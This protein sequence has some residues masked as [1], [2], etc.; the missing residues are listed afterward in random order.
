[1]KTLAER[2]RFRRNQMKM[3][4]GAVAKAVA[5]KRQRPFS[6][7]A[8]G[9]L[10]SGAAQ[11]SA[12]IATIAEVLECRLSWLRDGEGDPPQPPLRDAESSLDADFGR[13]NGDSVIEVD[14]RAGAGAG[15]LPIDAFVRDDAGNTYAAEVIRDEWKLPETIMRELLHA[16]PK[17]IRVFE[18]IGDS[19]V[20]P[21]SRQFSLYPGDRV[22]A[23][24]RDTTPSPEG[25]FVLWDGMG[26]VVKRLQ[27]I[28]NTEP[29][30]VKIISANPQ[31][32][33]YEAT[34]E[35]I[36]IIGRYGGR[37]TVN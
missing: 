18:V 23:N 27:V 1:M 35:E 12:E 22:F 19:M 34:I 31:Y 33:P 2:L 6:Q 24:L 13:N 14:V 9:A 20:N 4:Q 26:V 30:R 28:R 25:V 36:R 32:D 15:G 10:E 3:S 5:K 21:D 37:F 11:S 29:L 16:A 8:Y 17:H 7:Q